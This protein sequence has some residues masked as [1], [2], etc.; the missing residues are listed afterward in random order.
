MNDPN[1]ATL[2]VSFCKSS[3]SMGSAEGDRGLSVE[4][5]CNQNPSGDV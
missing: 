4:K 3:D 5:P 1:K 2:D